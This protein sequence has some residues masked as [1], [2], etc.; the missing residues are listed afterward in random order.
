MEGAKINKGV[1]QQILLL[2]TDSG[3][4][5]KDTTGNSD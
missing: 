1:Q 5:Q 3:Y 4:H 2:K